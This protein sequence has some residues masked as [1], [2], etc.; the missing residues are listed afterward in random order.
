MINWIINQRGLNINLRKT[1]TPLNLL[2]F[3]PK[4][5]RIKTWK[6][7]FFIYSGYLTFLSMRDYF[8]I[9]TFK[10][11]LWNYHSVHIYS[12][13]IIARA[14]G[15]DHTH[16]YALFPISKRGKIEV[17]G[18]WGR[19][20]KRRLEREGRKQ[21]VEGLSVTF[22]LGVFGEAIWVLTFWT[23]PTWTSS[24]SHIPRFFDMVICLIVAP[25]RISRLDTCASMTV[26][27]R[28]RQN[29]TILG[30]KG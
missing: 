4:Y 12:S 11:W 30:R 8:K 18:R 27:N 2:S 9:H 20:R 21:G 5:K 6:D 24:I 7:L 29:I 13:L 26:Q 25:N 22:Q 16:S 19:G 14:K 17:K 3:S 28:W 10:I 1:L 15:I 23:L